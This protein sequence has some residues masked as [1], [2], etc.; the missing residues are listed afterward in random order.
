MTNN[1]S[2]E[3]FEKVAFG[4][5]ALGGTVHESIT[6]KAAEFADMPYGSLIEGVQW[7]DAP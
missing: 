2:N 6:K 5:T 3:D 7:P 4:I 1:A